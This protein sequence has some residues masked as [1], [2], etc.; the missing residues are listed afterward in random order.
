MHEHIKHMVCAVY[1]TVHVHV[2]CLLSFNPS[3]MLMLQMTNGKQFII[4]R[5]R[6]AHYGKLRLPE[7]L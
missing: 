5:I 1:S 6:Y 2:H 7:H 4:E 3:G